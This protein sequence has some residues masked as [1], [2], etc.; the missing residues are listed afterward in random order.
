MENYIEIVGA[1]EN[2]LKNISLKIP[3]NKLVVLTGISGAGKSTLAFDILQKECQR[4]YMESMGMVNNLYSKPNVAF[5]KGLLPAISVT[6][7]SYNKSPRSTVG[8]VTDIF[9]YIRVLFAKLGMRVCS[10]GQEIFPTLQS[11]QRESMGV[12]EIN[13]TICPECG[14]PLEYLTSSSFSFNKPEGACP[15]CRGIGMVSEPDIDKV[16][17]MDLS[18]REGAI[19]GWDIVYIDRYGGSME[20]AG[21]YYGFEFDTNLPV[22]E[23]DEVCKDLLLYGTLSPQ[24]SRHFPDKKPPKTVPTGCF[25]GIVTNLMRRYSEASGESKQSDKL[26]KIMKTSICPACN[27]TR[28]RKESREVILG[29][30]TIVDILNMPIYEINS[31]IDGLMSTLTEERAE[32]ALSIIDNIRSRISSLINVGVGY[33]SLSRTISTLSGGEGQRL[34]LATLLSSALTGVLYILDEPSKGLHISEV[35]NLI[36]IIRKLQS[37]GNTILVIEHNPYIMQAAD[38][39]IDFGLKSGTNGG[40]IVACGTPEEVSRSKD[41]VTGKYIYNVSYYTNKIMDR[42]RKG[43]GKTLKIY[44]AQ[45]YNLK[46]INVEIP[47]NKFVVV[48]GVSGSGKS[49]L[50]FDILNKLIIGDEKLSDASI[51]GMEH[52]DSVITLEQSIVGNSV[53]S[54]VATYMDIFT[55]I[56]NLYAN[57]RQ[58]KSSKLGIKHFSFNVVGGRCEQ[59]EGMGLISIP[60]DFLP[61]VNAT[62]PSCQGK[63]FKEEV[64]RIIYNGHN[65]S[66]V[67]KM[68]IEEAVICF[69]DEPQIYKK[70]QILVDV[71]LS[72]LQLGQSISTLSGGESQRVRLA[73][74]LSKVKKGH[75]LYLFDEPTAGLHPEDIEGLLIVFN[76][77]IDQGHSVVVV[78]HNLQLISAADTIIDLGPEG[79]TLGGEIVAIGSPLELCGITASKT[80]A[81]LEEINCQR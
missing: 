9:T 5:M 72:Y 27:G 37:L 20:A 77:L 70:L 28:L 47:L 22:K 80:G 81:C 8:T 50:I 24:F 41:S 74:E 23:Y 61:D 36:D 14:T 4:Q 44:N 69:K 71:G 48:T 29:G 39:I 75:I 18:I 19:A 17:N 7:N 11:I 59:C 30:K 26:G 1:K 15:N 56:R 62:C 33:L 52:I 65:I 73:K 63:R 16:I 2:N 79:G 76:K 12:E 58:A 31:W 35:K 51:E 3:K 6:Q 54:N 78:E 34:R 66:D 49:T 10:C 40:E 38:Y 21:K 53:R 43:T 67:L 25:E 45:E 60:M 46:N 64:L 13:K 55:H 32:I 42:K 57:L 68:T